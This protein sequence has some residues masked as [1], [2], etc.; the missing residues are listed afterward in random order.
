MQALEDFKTLGMSTMYR[1][2]LDF[3]ACPVDLFSPLELEVLEVCPDGEITE[4]MPTVP[5]AP[6]CFRSVNRSQCLCRAW[7]ARVTEM[8]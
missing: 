2:L 4:G 5:P 3:L 6:E 7:T 8:K 1:E